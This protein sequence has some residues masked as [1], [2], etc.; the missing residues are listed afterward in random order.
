MNGDISQYKYDNIIQNLNLPGINLCT[1]F[2]TL[3]YK[4]RAELNELK[5]YESEQRRVAKRHPKGGSTQR[6]VPLLAHTASAPRRAAQPQTK[7]STP[8]SP[9]S[10][11]SGTIPRRPRLRGAAR[12]RCAHSNLLRC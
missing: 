11:G 10:S 2:A 5:A 1:I 8:Y 4:Q 6:N 3:C 7:N 9:E 12:F